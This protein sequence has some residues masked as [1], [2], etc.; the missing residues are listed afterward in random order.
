MIL[1]ILYVDW[2]HASL[3]EV[4]TQ[5][6]IK[7]VTL[8]IITIVTLLTVAVSTT[9]MIVGILTMIIITIPTHTHTTPLLTMKNQKRSLK[10]F[11]R[12]PTQPITTMRL[13]PIATTDISTDRTILLKSALVINSH[14]VNSLPGFLVS[15]NG[16]PTYSLFSLDE[17]E[18]F[19]K[20]EK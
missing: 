20:Q 9:N 16:S 19:I 14:S 11:L 12:S 3:V 5:I 13:H 18:K 15:S 2:K 7:I 8:L 17:L 4:L 1:F 6:T 10:M